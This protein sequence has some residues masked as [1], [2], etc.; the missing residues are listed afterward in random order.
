MPN[1]YEQ[2]I[3]DYQTTMP[4]ETESDYDRKSGRGQRL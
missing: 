3:S 1:N 4:Q 2:K